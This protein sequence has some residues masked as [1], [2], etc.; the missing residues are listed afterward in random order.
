M[1]KDRPPARP[2]LWRSD[3]SGRSWRQVWADSPAAQLTAL[4][5]DPADSRLLYAA[6]TTDGGAR[7][8]VSR[9][10]GATWA[11][12]AALPSAGER[13]YVNAQPRRVYVIHANS[14][15]SLQSGTW[16]HGPAF[17]DAGTLLTRYPQV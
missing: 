1:E 4:A 16:T 7:F 5:V 17:A 12:D 11:E 10:R 2:A 13:I 9:D 6:F 3:D 15:S 14:V 8:R